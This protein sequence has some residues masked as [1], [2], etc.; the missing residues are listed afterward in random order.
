MKAPQKNWLEWTVFAISTAVLVALVVTL[1]RFEVTRPDTPPE[2]RVHTLE[3][4]QAGRTFV[5]PVRVVNA[6]G[7]AAASVHVEVTLAGG[8][9]AE[10][11]E[12]V[13]PYVP[14]EAARNGEVVFE[15]DPRSGTLSARVLG[16]EIP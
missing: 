4:R 6:G 12:L 14:S 11:R 8:A 1:V 15:R 10:R 2:L 13:L 9:G 5:V 7:E 16:Y 3:P